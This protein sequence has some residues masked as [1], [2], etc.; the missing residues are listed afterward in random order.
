MSDV[1][2]GGD[3]FGLTELGREQAQKAAENLKEILAKDE[4]GYSPKNVLVMTS[5]LLRAKETAELIHQGLGC[6]AEVQVD[7]HLIERQFGELNLK[8]VEEYLEPIWWAD[9]QSMTRSIHG[10]EGVF[11]VAQRMIELIRVLEQKCSGKVF[12]LVS[13]G[14]PILK[15]KVL[16]HGLPLNYLPHRGSIGNCSIT[17]FRF[18]QENMD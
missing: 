2:D 18:S 16:Y 17:P 15:M 12:V 11:D 13:H 5:P 4:N 9:L 1:K 6:K 8:S 14:D 3:K 10:V 7:Q